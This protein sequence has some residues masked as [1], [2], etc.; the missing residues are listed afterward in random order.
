MRCFDDWAADQTILAVVCRLVG[1]DTQR[2]IDFEEA[3]TFVPV[4]VGVEIE[5]V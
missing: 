4:N 3:F 5:R 1:H 2:Q